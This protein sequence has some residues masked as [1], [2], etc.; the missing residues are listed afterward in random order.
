MNIKKALAETKGC[1]QRDEEWRAIAKEAYDL[2]IKRKVYEA[3]EKELLSRLKVLSKFE[4]SAAG[5]YMFIAN[6]RLGTL[7]YSLIPEF[8]DLDKSYLEEFR[9]DSVLSWRL[10]KI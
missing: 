6:E 8:K 2:A 1:V 3:R 10:T 4:S 5:E 9:K 7:N